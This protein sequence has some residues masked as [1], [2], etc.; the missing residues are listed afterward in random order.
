MLLYLDRNKFNV[1]H[2][3]T[4]PLSHVVIDNLHLFLRV[5]DILINLLITE[6]RCQDSIDQRKRFT[7]QFD[8]SKFKH[9]ENYEKFVSSL[10]I[11]SFQFY[12]GEASKELKCRSLTGPVKLK[13]FDSI[14]IKSLL[15]TISEDTS[16]RIQHLWSELLELNKL[17]CLSS[18]KLTTP[19]IQQYEQ[20][21]RQWGRNFIDVYHTDKVTPYIHA[22][23]NHVSEFMRIHGSIVPFTQQGLEKHN[24]VMTKIY[25]RAS[26]HRGLQALRQ[27]IEKR[28]RIEYFMD[29]DTKRPK[30]HDIRCSN[31]DESGH[32]RLTC[33]KPCKLCGEPYAP[34]LTIIEHSGTKVPICDAENYM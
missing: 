6:L 26:S 16:I 24:D 8:V 22:M 2:V 25:F 10:G 21:A 4:I 11:P 20:R 19:T 1:S 31:C 34:H 27:I 13:V 5:A 23:M 29:N 18:T 15:P 12:V 7:G 3:P 28:N 17:I 32:N 33:S 30:K 9:L 14:D